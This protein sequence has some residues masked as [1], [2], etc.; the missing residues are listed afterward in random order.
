M[1]YRIFIINSDNSIDTISQ[2]SFDDFS[3]RD[4]PVFTRYAGQDIHVAMVF[5]TLRDKKPDEIKKIDSFRLT[6][7]NNGAIDHDR[8][9]DAL[10][11]SMNLGFEGLNKQFK[12]TPSKSVIDAKSKFDE[13]RRAQF[14]PEISAAAIN[15]I[16]Q[17]LFRYKA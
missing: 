12:S 8:R 4:E 5:Y 7:K 1:S 17:K 9:L 6:V 16:L 15:K 2:K 13:R 14:N 3:R 10:S 11:L